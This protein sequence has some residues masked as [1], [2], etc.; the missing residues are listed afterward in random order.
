MYT[1]RSQIN[2]SIQPILVH[3]VRRRPSIKSTLAQ[4]WRFLGSDLQ[5]RR[6]CMPINWAENLKELDLNP[7]HVID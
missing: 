6:Q 3:R 1:L 7:G 2:D 5:S 4:R